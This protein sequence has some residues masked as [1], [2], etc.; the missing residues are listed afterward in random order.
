MDRLPPYLPYVTT[1]GYANITTNYPA[2]SYSGKKARCTDLKCDLFSD[3]T[4]W[5]PV[6]GLAV[7][8]V[9]GTSY[10]IAP[11]GT[12]GTGS[13]GHWTCGTAAPRAFT[14]GLWLY[15]A[16]TATTPALAAGT[17]WVVMSSTTVGTI[18]T[19]GP[20]SAA[21]NF[22]GGASNT[23]STAEWTAK[24]VT[25]PAGCLGSTGQLECVG[26][27][28]STNNANGKV[29]RGKLAGSLLLASSPTTSVTCSLHGVI[30]NKTANSQVGQ[31]PWQT[32]TSGVAVTTASVNTYAAVALTYTLQLT[33][34]AD[35]L[36]YERLSTTLKR[37]S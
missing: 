24:T 13:S 15:F 6:S 34:A 2:A 35:W 28:V 37:T 36:V 4:S 20:G 27:S 10:G 8:D 17:Y 25:I 30:A 5:L 16:A 9:D 1:D 29:V 14:E 33:N 19:A 26:F 22:T 12:I 32:G 18:Y 31:N 7:I 21:F 11:S 3:G 23:G